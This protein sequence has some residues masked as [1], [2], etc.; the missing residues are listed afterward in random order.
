MLRTLLA[1]TLGI[2][3][4]VAWGSLS[5]AGSLLDS[6]GRFAH[7]CMVNWSRLNLRLAA[8]RVEIAG[9]EHV[10]ANRP[11]LFVVNHQS[12]V[13]ILVLATVLP[14]RFGFVAKSELFH[15]PFLGWHMRRAGF[16]P[17]DRQHPRR[18]AR[19]LLEAAERIR[20][21]LNAVV[22][23]EG[24]RSPAGALLPFRGG[25]FLLAIRAGVPIVPVVLRGTAGIVRKGEWS[26]HPATARVACLSPIDPTSAG[27][28][29]ALLSKQVRQAME[30]GL[31]DLDRQTI[32]DGGR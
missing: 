25:A 13:D 27:E 21:G 30:V 17:I 28:D 10:S 18:A 15:I 4:T 6:S 19:T 2:P 8:T 3:N 1:W 26:V 31:A 14:V 16:I 7:L 5:L 24:T 29:R 12:L 9:L 20:G 11:Q 23:P 22:F 32:I